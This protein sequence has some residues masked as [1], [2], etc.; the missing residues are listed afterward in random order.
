MSGIATAIA[1]GA[2]VSSLIG[3]N[4]SQSAANTQASAANNATNAQLQMFGQTQ[5][6]L[7]PW[8][9]A[10]TASLA[11]LQAALGI[12]GGGG[13]GSAPGV[14]ALPGGGTS[15]SNYMPTAGGGIQ[16]MLGLAPG[17]ATPQ[18]SAGPAVRPGGTSSPMNLTQILQ[19]TP[20]YQWDVS[21]GQQ[22]ILDQASAMGGVNSGATMKALSDYTSNQANN[23]YQQYLT[24]LMNQSNAGAN[25]AANVGQAGTAVGGQIGSNMIGAGNAL[26][27][28]TIGSANAISGGLQGGF[29]NYLMYQALNQNPYGGF[30]GV[31]SLNAAYNGGSAADQWNATIG[32]N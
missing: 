4:A 19:N 25:A 30:S 9:N 12:G 24:N 16:Q 13:G 14:N 3:S 32:L 23:T 15:T 2:L 31:G 22:S 7:Q 27:A 10:G 6:N 18:R 28:G 11:Q 29:N 8:M 17:G 26:A 5:A 21:Q 20:G 1:G